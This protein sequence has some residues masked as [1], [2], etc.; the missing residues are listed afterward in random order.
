M[1]S[2][3][4]VAMIPARMGSK[5]IPKKNIRYMLDKP[6][7]QYPIDLARESGAFES[8]WISTES[9]G[10]GCAG[11]RMGAQF[12]RRPQELSSDTATNRDFVYEFLKRHECDYV[13]MLNPTS[14][15]LRLDTLKRFIMY[16]QNNSYDTIMSVVSLQAEGFING[17][18]INFDGHDK[19]PSQILTPID[20]VIWAVTAWKRD[21]FINLE[22]N[23]QCPVFGGNLGCFV[24]PK[25]EAAD[26]DTEEDWRIAEAVLLARKSSASEEGTRYLNID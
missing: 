20:T 26:L 19:I 4:L 15:A 9:E 21:T 23:G 25:D 3:K 18:K 17:E 11:E 13:V 14:P 10:L 8:I 6:L 5:R 16:L 1:N 12:H 7:I 24:I 2:Y 22:E